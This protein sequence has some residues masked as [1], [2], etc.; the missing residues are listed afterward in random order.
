M[1]IIAAIDYYKYIF[2]KQ[3]HSR[4]HASGVYL[5]V[6]VGDASGHDAAVPGARG[7]ALSAAVRHRQVPAPAQL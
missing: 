1:H 5:G 3:N 4:R 6:R 7:Q 2:F